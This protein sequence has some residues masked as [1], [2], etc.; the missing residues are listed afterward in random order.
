MGHVPHLFIP[1]P[2]EEPELG[3][4]GQQAQHLDRV[5]RRDRGAPVTY[6]NGRGLAGA[7]LW[8]GEGVERGEEAHEAPMSVR[9]HM[10]VAA[11]R[12]AER[13]RFLVEK[14]AELGVA[15]LRWLATIHGSG[16]LPRRERAHAWAVAALEQSRGVYLMEINAEAVPPAELM[17]P[18][19]VA[20]QGGRP[21]SR[22][23]SPRSGTVTV[24]VGPEGGFSVDE[25]PGHAEPLSL[26]PRILRVETAAVVAATLILINT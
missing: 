13:Q 11:P 23:Y 22:A 5:L 25:L 14:L 17:P 12:A 16:R 6:T 20:D 4:S 19:L 3:V 24:A 2:W 8:T 10:A 21:L 15:E 7:G 9:V 1:D 18:L 26:G